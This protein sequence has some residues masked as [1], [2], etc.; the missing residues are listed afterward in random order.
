MFLRQ[1]RQ[2]DIVLIDNKL[3][4]SASRNKFQRSY[5]SI[6]I[7]PDMFDILNKVIFVA[8]PRFITEEQYFETLSGNVTTLGIFT[9]PNEFKSNDFKRIQF[10]Y[11]S[12]KVYPMKCVDTDAVGAVH[13]YTQVAEFYVHFFEK[14]GDYYRICNVG[15]SKKF[16]FGDI[17]RSMDV[18]GLLV[19]RYNNECNIMVPSSAEQFQFNYNSSKFLDCNR[20]SMD[21]LYSLQRLKMKGNSLKKRFFMSGGTLLGWYRQCGIILQ[22]KDVDFAMLKD[23]FEDNVPNSFRGDN[24]LYLVLQFGTEPGP[25]EFRISNGL[26]TFDLFV[27]KYDPEHDALIGIYQAALKNYKR[28]TPPI[29][30]ICSAELLDMRL[31]VP[32]VCITRSSTSLFGESLNDLIHFRGR[33]FIEHTLVKCVEIVGHLPF[34]IFFSDNHLKHSTISLADL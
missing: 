22:S 23:E 14:K 3:I 15:L 8:D 28:R 13:V 17:A 2:N 19:K 5:S 16:S 21:W 33:C 32:L 34:L 7:V 11:P 4:W 29:T 30:E 24:Q 1:K 18:F 26:Y 6:C 20:S 10:V 9:E 31:L 12:I 25:L 27:L